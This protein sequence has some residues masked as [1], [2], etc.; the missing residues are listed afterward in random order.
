MESNNAKSGPDSQS[1]SGNS[2]LP[3]MSRLADELLIALVTTI[4]V[5][6]LAVAG[7]RLFTLP[8]WTALL[9]LL[10]VLLLLITIILA[11][12]IKQRAARSLQLDLYKE[13]SAARCGDLYIQLLRNYFS[14]RR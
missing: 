2:P 3:R 1:S 13:V 5:G 11:G 8:V 6:V 7:R 4:I 10:L 9:I 14:R 12:T